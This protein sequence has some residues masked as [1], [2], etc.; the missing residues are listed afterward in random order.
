MANYNKITTSRYAFCSSILENYSTHKFLV[1]IAKPEDGF[2]QGFSRKIKI[3][4]NYIIISQPKRIY[5]D[6]PKKECEIPHFR[7]TLY[8]VRFIVFLSSRERIWPR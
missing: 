2:H 3:H 8:L 6:E 4:M 5:N 7:K 1:Q